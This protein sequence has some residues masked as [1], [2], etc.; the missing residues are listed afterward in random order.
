MKFVNVDDMKRG[1]T[2]TV[3]GEKFIIYRLVIGVVKLF[4]EYELYTLD[5]MKRLADMKS[6]DSLST[7]ELEEFQEQLSE[8]YEKF[9]EK[10][11]DYL[12]RILEGILQ[13]NGYEFD[14]EW[15][16]SNADY[17]DIENFIHVAMAKDHVEEKEQK[18]NGSQI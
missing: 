11:A 17:R 2:I 5:A 4:G 7:E 13:N 10:K 15:W 1:V 9:V 16:Y 3:G 12:E 18:K 6:L 8:S 14:R